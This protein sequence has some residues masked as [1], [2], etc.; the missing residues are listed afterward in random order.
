M[1]KS[2]VI[3]LA[4]H[5]FQTESI[6][7]FL[8][9]FICLGFCVLVCCLGFDLVFCLCFVWLVWSGFVCFFWDFFFF[10]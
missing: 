3:V 1:L 5:L 6:L 10:F 4:C 2:C 9:F 7:K 8:G